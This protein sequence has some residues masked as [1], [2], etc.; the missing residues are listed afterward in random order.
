MKK[1]GIVSFD[2]DMTL[3]NH[4]DWRIPDSA[5]QAI[6]ALRQNYLIVIASGRDMDNCYSYQYRDL[7]KPDAIIHLNGT[8]VTVGD[9]LIFEHY[10]NREL[11]ERISAFVKDKPYALGLTVGTEDYYINPEHVIKHDVLR[12]KE[13]ARNFQSPERLPDL[14]IRTLTYLGNEAGVREIEAAF[15]EIK[16]PMFSD[17]TGADVVE[18]TASKARGLKRLCDYFDIP[19]SRTVAFGDSMN[20]Y[21]IIKEAGIGVA[22]GNALDMLKQVADYVTDRI[23]Q[24]GVYKACTGLGLID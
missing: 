5:M 20:D 6:E 24:D 10:M 21:E 18:R 19:V 3:L 8:K 15:P 13:S 22:M 2:L 16:L 12:W 9:K 7:I 17:R 14:K 11:L 1:R 4:K 23:D